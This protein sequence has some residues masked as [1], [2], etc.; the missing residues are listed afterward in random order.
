MVAS[1]SKMVV[2]RGSDKSSETSAE[3]ASMHGMNMAQAAVD[4]RREQRGPDLRYQQ[5]DQRLL[6]CVAAAYPVNSPNAD[7][8]AKMAMRTIV[9]AGWR[10][11]CVGRV[12]AEHPCRGE[13][14]KEG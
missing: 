8:A 6:G 14:A 7:V 5:A 12:R 1:G 3:T 2:K 13:R 10:L 11:S 4:N 9:W